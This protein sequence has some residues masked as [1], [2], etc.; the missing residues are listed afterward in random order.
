M[1]NTFNA[2]LR[3][4]RKEKGITQEQ[5]A[6][7]AG[8]SPQAVSKWEMNSFPDAAL[9]PKIAEKLEVSIDELYGLKDESI[10]IYDRVMLHIRNTPN[11]KRFDEV[12]SIFRECTNCSRSSS[13]Y[14]NT[15]TKSR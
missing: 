13:S 12:F 3:R 14:G 9:L 5:L 2:N 1:D 10:S 11:E 8:V 6:D 15:S 7:F 4:I